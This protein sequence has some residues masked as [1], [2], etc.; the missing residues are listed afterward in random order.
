M[1]EI[2]NLII[3]NEKLIY[4]ICNYFKNYSSKEDLYQAGCLGLISAYKKYNPNM[5]CKFTTYAYPYILGEMRKL[6]RED[7]GMKIS[8]EIT[9]LNLKIE[10]AYILLTQKLM[11]EPSIEEIAN[12]LE[13]PEYYVSEAILSLNKIKSIDE[14]V[15]SEGR[16]FTLQDVIGKSENVD[17]LIMLKELLQNLKLSGISAKIIILSG[18]NDFEYAKRAM[19][20]GVKHYLLKPIE[21]KK[22]IETVKSACDEI[23]DDMKNPNFMETVK[24]QIILRGLLEG[25]SIQNLKDFGLV[26][27]AESFVVISV[28]IIDEREK[29]ENLVHTTMLLESVEFC[30]GMDTHFTI[31]VLVGKDVVLIFFA[32]EGKI[33]ED[34]LLKRIK[35]NFMSKSKL[36]LIFGVSSIGDDLGQLRELYQQS[37]MALD[38]IKR[39]VPKEIQTY[40]KIK[41][42]TEII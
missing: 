3:N 17:D 27:P 42:D 35:E 2:T 16:E 14:P 23:D 4:S 36:K 40:C 26:V 33:G 13:I 37:L 21:N 7:K 9:K 6:V 12:Y 11:K 41:R 30:L 38:S 15:S 34:K 25:S 5:N 39:I 31:P 19:E 28:K 20:L 10:K 24:H 29:E 18:F 22:L 1:D 32:K 8:R